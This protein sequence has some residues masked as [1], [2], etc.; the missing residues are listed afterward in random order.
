MEDTSHILGGDARKRLFKPNNRAAVGVRGK[1]QFKQALADFTVR[2]VLATPKLFVH[3]LLLMVEIS[4]S[5]QRMQHGITEHI[6]AGF[7]EAAGNGDMVDRLVVARP[8]IHRASGAFNQRRN[9]PVR[10]A[11]R[12]FEQH[13]LEHMGNARNVEISSALP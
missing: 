4:G 1:R 6:E 2:V 5:E 12:A 11:L 9:F 13:M 3:H 10:K 7:P 8:G